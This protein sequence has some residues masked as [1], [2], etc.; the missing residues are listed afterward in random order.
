M[1]G[2]RE[3]DEAISDDQ[4]RRWR[5]EEGEQ[6][7]EQGTRAHSTPVIRHPPSAIHCTAER[8]GFNGELRGRCCSGAR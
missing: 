8:L 1:S 6:D 7:P 3:E 4:Q 2:Q 5:E